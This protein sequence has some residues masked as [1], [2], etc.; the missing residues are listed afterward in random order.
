MSRLRTTS[1]PCWRTTSSS[2]STFVTILKANRRQL[3][4]LSFVCW[5]FFL[6]NMH[7]IVLIAEVLLER[8]VKPALSQVRLAITH[9]FYYKLV[10]Y[11]QSEYFLCYLLIFSLNFIKLLFAIVVV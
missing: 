10:F 5:Y 7:N 8:M 2:I 11:L 3:A 4:E 6:S 9:K 1:A